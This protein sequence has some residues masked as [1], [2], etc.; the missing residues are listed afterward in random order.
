MGISAIIYFVGACS[1]LI[2]AIYENYR[3]K[4]LVKSWFNFEDIIIVLFSWISVII[5]AYFVLIKKRGA[6]FDDGEDKTS[7]QG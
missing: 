4:E 3:N 2:I 6:H 5:W 1:A 7:E